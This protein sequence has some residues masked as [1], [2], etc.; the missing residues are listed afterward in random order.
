MTYNVHLT[1]GVTSCCSFPNKL[2]RNLSTNISI[3]LIPLN[4]PRNNVLRVL[5]LDLG[6][7]NKLRVARYYIQHTGSLSRHPKAKL[8]LNYT[9]GLP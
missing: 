9:I 7:Q 8:I 6:W 3:M 1:F 2:E 4:T 5:P